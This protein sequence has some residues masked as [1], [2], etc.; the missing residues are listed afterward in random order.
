MCFNL[1]SF[2]IN[3]PFAVYWNPPGAKLKIV[4]IALFAKITFFQFLSDCN[5]FI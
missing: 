5:F 2:G 3:M 1:R 4:K